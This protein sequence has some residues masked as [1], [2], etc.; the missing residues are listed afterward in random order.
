MHISF[1]PKITVIM[2]DIFLNQCDTHK[3]AKVVHENQS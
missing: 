1:R 2:L 3:V